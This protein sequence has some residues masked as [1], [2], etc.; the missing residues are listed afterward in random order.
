ML[1]RSTDFL[2][3][4]AKLGGLKVISEP[5]RAKGEVLIVHDPLS[6]PPEETEDRPVLDAETLISIVGPE[7]LAH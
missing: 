4:V 6:V 3:E 7:I 5:S 1:F 2:E